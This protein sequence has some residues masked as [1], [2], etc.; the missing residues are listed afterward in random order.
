MES[1]LNVFNQYLMHVHFNNSIDHLTLVNISHES[2]DDHQSSF[3]FII[4]LH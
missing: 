1:M 3:C 4:K 2:L